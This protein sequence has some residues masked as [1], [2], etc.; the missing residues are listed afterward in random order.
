[1]CLYIYIYTYPFTPDHHLLNLLM[2]QPLRSLWC[3]FPKAL[4]LGSRLLRFA[5]TSISEALAKWLMPGTNK[6][7]ATTAEKKFCYFMVFPLN[8]L[9]VEIIW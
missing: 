7:S 3:A 5:S 6:A 1:M 8:L 2:W 4:H 9:C